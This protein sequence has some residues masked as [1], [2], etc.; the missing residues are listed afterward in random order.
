MLK[1]YI[2]LLSLSI[3]CKISVA[4]V[5]NNKQTYTIS[6]NVVKAHV[7]PTMYGI[8]FEDINLAADGGVY[9]ELIKNRSF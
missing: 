3:C 1:K 8:F 6:A 9:A 5:I 7:E 4:Q 2:V